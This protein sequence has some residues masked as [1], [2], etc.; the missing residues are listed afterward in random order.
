MKRIRKGI[1]FELTPEVVDIGE[2]WVTLTIK[3]KSQETLRNLDI[4]LN[5][6]DTLGLDVRDSAKYVP[7]LL[8]DEKINLFFRANIFFSTRVYVSMTGYRNE[9]LFYWETPDMLVKISTQMAE[10]ISMFATTTPQPIIGDTIKCVARISVKD[11]VDDLDLETWIEAP[12]GEI[13]EVEII[14]LDE[15]GPGEIKEY[16][17]EFT[18]KIKGVYIVRSQLFKGI[19]RLSSKTDYVYV[20]EK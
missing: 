7:I 13:E 4:H 2:R 19:K 11:H 9:E 1:E 18:P 20:E 8:P 5:S 12:D 14:S 17:S 15:A 16:I 10:I 3:N 6:I